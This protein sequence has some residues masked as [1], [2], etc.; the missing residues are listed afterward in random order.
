MTL[1]EQFQGVH[2]TDWAYL[3]R[4]EL[5]RPQ[6]DFSREELIALAHDKGVFDTVFETPNEKKLQVINGYLCYE[7]LPYSQLDPM[8]QQEY[9]KRFFSKR[10][11]NIQ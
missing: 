7:G 10:T 2:C 5:T 11:E 6:P 3:I 1:T 8:E 9:R 4:K